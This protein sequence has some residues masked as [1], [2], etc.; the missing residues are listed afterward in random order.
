MHSR[1]VLIIVFLASLL[2]NSTLSQFLTFKKEDSFPYLKTKH[3]DLSFVVG[4][5]FLHGESVMIKTL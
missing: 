2:R 5:G 3:L 4:S 1:N